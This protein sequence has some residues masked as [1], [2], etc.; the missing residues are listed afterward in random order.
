M[1]PSIT[2]S[3]GLCPG[4]RG[5]DRHI[6]LGHIAWIAG[7]SPKW[8][9]TNVECPFCHRPL[10]TVTNAHEV[11]LGRIVRE[12]DKGVPYCNGTLKDDLPPTHDILFCRDCKI[13]FSTLK[14]SK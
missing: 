13:P 6:P 10:R 4:S 5:G 7:R 14:E 11:G 8:G 12:C 1:K 3:P 2:G 9:P